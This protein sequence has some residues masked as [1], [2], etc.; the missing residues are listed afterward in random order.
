MKLSRSAKRTPVFEIGSGNV[1]ADI[2]VPD[3]GAALAKAEI[4]REI[5]SSIRKRGLTQSAAADLLGIDQPRVSY[6]LRGRL[7]PFSLEKLMAFAAKLGN[8][9][10]VRVLP[11]ATP[12]IRF[13]KTPVDV[14]LYT[15]FDAV[16]PMAF[17]DNQTSRP[18]WLASKLTED[19][20]GLYEFN[21]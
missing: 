21:G 7:Q 5:A 11:A 13:T 1:F 16:S 9:V 4:A 8:A 6:L 10:E 15:R 18:A 2:G 14:R 20:A 19:A 17:I 12:G 3:A